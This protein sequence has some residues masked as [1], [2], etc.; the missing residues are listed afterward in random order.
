M[1]GEAAMTLNEAIGVA[2]LIRAA[3]RAADEA[4]ELATRDAD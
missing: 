4:A 1:C 3:V 2:N